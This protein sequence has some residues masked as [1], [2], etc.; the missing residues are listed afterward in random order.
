MA[1]QL[2]A[3]SVCH[4]HRCVTSGEEEEREGEIDF[5]HGIVGFFNNIICTK[6]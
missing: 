4:M 2:S 3:N 5:Y 1:V 6:N